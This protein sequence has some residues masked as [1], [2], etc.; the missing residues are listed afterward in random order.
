MKNFKNILTK[1][2]AAVPIIFIFFMPL[3]LSFLAAPSAVLADSA[4]IHSNVWSPTTLAGPLITCVGAAPAAGG[5]SGGVTQTCSSFCDLVSTAANLV[6]FAIAF[7][8]WIIA[9]IMF[10]WAGILFMISTGSAERTG[11]ARKM[12][13]GTVIGLLIVLCAYLLVLTLVNV[14]QIQNYVGGFGTAAC[15]LTS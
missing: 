8:I 10:L 6:Y 1:A 3:M 15:T 4:T 9:P 7:V 13:T 2:S 5:V 11:Q 12:I 14:L